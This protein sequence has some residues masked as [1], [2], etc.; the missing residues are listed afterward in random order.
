MVLEMFDF[1]RFLVVNTNLSLRVTLIVL[2]VYVW[3]FFGA[4]VQSCNFTFTRFV[5][6]FRDY[7]CAN[8]CFVNV[9]AEVRNEGVLVQSKDGDDNKTFYELLNHGFS[10][11][12]GRARIVAN[13]LRTLALPVA[14]ARFVW[15][16]SGNNRAA[17]I[18]FYEPRVLAF[19]DDG[20]IVPGS[21]Y[22]ARM[23]QSS[24]G[25]DQLSGVIQ[26]IKNQPSS[27]RRAAITIYLPYDAV[28]E[29]SDI[30]CAFGMVYHPRSEKLHSTI[31]MR[32]N[33]AVSL[34]PFNLFEF[35]G[36]IYLTEQATR[37]EN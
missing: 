2:R 12:D 10:F 15:M 4:I 26:R 35:S 34:L 8:S 21:S 18:A 13:S 22:G 25:V 11:K 30:P 27:T 36:I 17:D 33:N 37:I 19:S 9:L 31:F 5:M 24:P 7:S 23:L 28:R 14:A 6:N 20:I 16:M 1:R 32:S 29:S 3:N